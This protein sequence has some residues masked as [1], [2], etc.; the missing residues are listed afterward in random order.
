MFEFL[1]KAGG[2][3]EIP[4]TKIYYCYGVRQHLFEEMEKMLPNVQFVDGLP[5]KQ[6][7]E[8]WS[9]ENRHSIVVLD[10]LINSLDKQV[11]IANLFC[12]YSH[13]MMITVFLLV[14]NLYA[15]SKYFR[16]LSLNSHYIILFRNA[17]DELQIRR[18]AGQMMPGKTE[19]FMDSYTRAT[20]PNFG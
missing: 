15:S 9:A 20:K 8:E 17:L 19:Y 10:D 3:F 2:T 4:P 7:F 5:N 14:Q 13:H 12:Q 16:V 6:M 18:L 11:E 1:K